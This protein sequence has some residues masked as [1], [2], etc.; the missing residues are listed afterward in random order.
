MTLAVAAPV[1]AGGAQHF[2]MTNVVDKQTLTGRVCV[3]V[4]L[5]GTTPDD[6]PG[7]GID[8]LVDGVDYGQAI[9]KQQDQSTSVGE[10]YVDT[11]T[12]ANGDHTLQLTDQ[13]GAT[14]DR[15]V[16]FKNPLSSYN[17][18]TDSGTTYVTATLTPSQKWV[19]TVSDSYGKVIHKF[20]GTG[21]KLAFQ[22]SKDSDALIPGPFAL[23]VK[24]LAS[25]QIVKDLIDQ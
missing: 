19:G 23:K 3:K 12:Y 13:N 1:L 16:N 22:W 20:S 11:Y 2:R 24:A 9:Y 10:F 21:G 5:D 18:T 8:F 4:S 15:S 17:R 7:G 6:N 14:D 25:G